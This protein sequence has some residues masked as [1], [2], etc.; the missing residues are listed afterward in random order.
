MN[1]ESK[2]SHFIVGASGRINDA[3]LFR[4]FSINERVRVMD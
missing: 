3:S 2:N 4:Y 1:D